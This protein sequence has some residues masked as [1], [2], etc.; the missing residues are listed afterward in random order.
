MKTSTLYRF[1]YIYLALPLFIFL[2]SWLDFGIGLILDILLGYGFYKIYPKDSDE[3][4]NLNINTLLLFVIIA[5]I[6]CFCG[7]IGYFYHQP[8]DYHFRNAVFRDLIN[9]EWPVFYDKANT[10]MVYYMAFWLIPAL[11][12]KLLVLC[13]ASLEGAF[14]GANVFL[15]MYAIFGT[16]LIFIHVIKAINADCK[17]KIFTA[18]FLFIFF[19][20]LDIIGHKFFLIVEPPFEYHLDWWAAHIQYSSLT[21][22][23][24][25]V[26][27][28]FIP[29]CLLIFLIY[30]EKKVKSFGFLIPISLFF[31]PYP[32]AS[33]GVF[34]LVYA[35]Q[36]FVISVNKKEFVFENILSI[37][38]LIGVFWILPVVIMYFITNTEGMYGYY[39]IFS[40]TTPFRLLLFYT[41]EFLLYV[42]ILY[43]KYKM[44]IFFKTV[45]V[46]LIAIPFLRL[47]QQNNFCM[48]A[49]IPAL[50]ILSIYAIRF[51]LYS[52]NSITKYVFIGLFI[53]GSITPI[54]EF[55]RGFHYT[56]KAKKINLVADEIYTLNK[57]LVIMPVFYW[58]ANHQYTA[59]NYKTDFF[60]QYMA[61]KTKGLNKN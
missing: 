6:W 58:D 49:A 3:T 35:I 26:F 2:I 33:I 38:N 42:T 50:V 37:P 40:Y 31:A 39:Y 45:I 10:P 52:P 17:K 29:V 23:M 1:T 22:S 57:K 8:F 36:Q 30:N 44:D 18:I 59:K 46:L 55:Y 24:F 16:V 27:N 43:P 9:F 41:L 54:V 53:I 60:W 28:Q 21:T 20:G 61:K 12:G 32:T 13:G 5:F 15:L 25:W 14:L 19:S 48:R 4:L 47:D 7:G 56:S 51:V 34:M 11:V